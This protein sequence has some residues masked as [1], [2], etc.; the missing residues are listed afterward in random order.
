MT[1]PLAQRLDAGESPTDEHHRDPAGHRHV[2]HPLPAPLVHPNR[3]HPALQARQLGGGACDGHL[4]QPPGPVDGIYDAVSGQSNRTLAASRGEPV[5][6]ITARGPDLD[7]CLSNTYLS[8]GPRAPTQGQSR[9]NAKS[10]FDQQF[11]STARFAGGHY[12][13]NS[14]LLLPE[15]LH[16]GY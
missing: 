8:A 10:C 16:R 12:C 14:F 9:R 7:R 4:A 13:I 11:L 15:L 2:G 3:G 6:S 5:A 1:P